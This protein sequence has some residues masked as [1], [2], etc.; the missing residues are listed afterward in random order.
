MDNMQWCTQAWIA[1]ANSE[2][3]V[4]IQ[5]CAHHL[6]SLELAVKLSVS[7]GVPCPV[8]TTLLGIYP[9]VQHSFLSVALCSPSSND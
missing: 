3:S 9:V 7:V 4:Y 5:P 1:E 2:V 6:A 8:P